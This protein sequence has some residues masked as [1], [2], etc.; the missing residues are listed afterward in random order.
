MLINCPECELQVS[1]KA[2]SCPHCGYPL[3]PEKISRTR[4][5]SKRQRLPNGFG[6]ISEIKNKQLSKPFRAMVTTGKNQFG[7]PICKLL[8]PQAYFATYNEA[9]AALVEYNRNP[10]DFD[11]GISFKELYERWHEDKKNS[12]SYA[13]SSLYE[14]TFKL[15]SMVY[16]QPIRNI[17]QRHIKACMDTVDSPRIKSNIKMLFNQ[18]FDY[19]T[20]YE[21]IDVNYS[22]NFKIPKE[23]SKTVKK[24]EHSHISYT[25]EEMRLLWESDEYLAMLVLIQCYSGWRPGEMANL[26]VDDVSVSEWTMKGGMKTEAGIDRI[27]PVHPKIRPLVLQCYSE[28][29]R[30]DS[31]YLFNFPLSNKTV[32]LTINSYTYQMKKLVSKLGLNPDHRPHDGRK[33]FVTMA[34]RAGV[35]EYAIKYLVGHVIADITEKV[36]TD[37]DLNWL[38]SELEKIK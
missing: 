34:K 2:L 4:K 19:A 1:D 14:R 11:E 21:L 25:D 32:K 33:Q 20:E 13:M 38:R 18:L 29:K 16:E 28:A 12:I 36:Y 17:R 5:S 23:I 35:D 30:L 37:R 15:C 6:Q 8:Q 31:E 24:T 27:V 9:Y 10:Y 22:R 3:K 7:K 26:R